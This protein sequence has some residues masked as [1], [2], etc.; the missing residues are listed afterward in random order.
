MKRN[1]ESKKIFYGLGEQYNSKENT[2]TRD[3]IA[4]PRFLRSPRQGSL[5]SPRVLNLDEEEGQLD[6]PKQAIEF[7][8]ASCLVEAETLVALSEDR[9]AR[10]DEI[11]LD[12]NYD[13][14][15]LDEEILNNRAEEEPALRQEIPEV[16]VVAPAPVQ[17][18]PVAERLH[19]SVYENRDYPCAEFL[20]RPINTKKKILLEL[21]Y[22]EG[23]RFLCADNR[24]QRYWGIY[25]SHEEIVIQGM[26]NPYNQ[27]YLYRLLTDHRYYPTWV[28]AV[29]KDRNGEF[30]PVHIVSK[31]SLGSVKNMISY[32]T[33]IMKQF[34]S[35]KFVRRWPD[36][37]GKQCLI[38]T[39]DSEQQKRHLIAEYE[40][41]VAKLG[42]ETDD[43]LPSFRIFYNGTLSEVINA[44][45]VRQ[46]SILDFVEVQPEPNVYPYVKRRL[47]LLNL[48]KE[49]LN[50]CVKGGLS[51]HDFNR[52]CDLF[53]SPAILSHEVALA[54]FTLSQIIK[55]TGVRIG[56]R[57][58]L[59]DLKGKIYAKYA[60][61]PAFNDQRVTTLLQMM[62]QSILAR[63]NSI[64][65]LIDLRIYVLRLCSIFSVDHNDAKMEYFVF[66]RLAA[67]MKSRGHENIQ[68][69]ETFQSCSQLIVW[70]LKKN[71][72]LTV[73]QDGIS[74][75]I[76]PAELVG[77]IEENI[78]AENVRILAH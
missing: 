23:A 8:D 25:P 58:R 4:S 43:L 65:K 78:R 68:L 13:D 17:Q 53:I 44:R 7:V 41:F 57:Q 42:A 18:A 38:I 63:T 12:L 29:V 33:K 54:Y 76:T 1:R 62:D 14:L 31:S 24:G 77:Q 60:N 6:S 52:A 27:F 47:E 26:L 11:R 32:P 55:Y 66:N 35:D 39:V 50:N 64:N 36:G 61:T 72:N 45:R 71:I 15:M 34:S 10:A 30:S 74:R 59:I 16:L 51:Q 67:V 40:S 28:S 70:M 2:P 3:A 73:E 49:L 56:S 22:K 9:Y 5:L 48:E 20:T 46:Q 69:Q 21:L 75:N 37:L 19:L